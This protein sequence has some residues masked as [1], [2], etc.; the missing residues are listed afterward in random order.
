M[1][2]LVFGSEMIRVGESAHPGEEPAMKEDGA[3]AVFGA[4]SEEKF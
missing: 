3:F 1:K 2:C 4:L